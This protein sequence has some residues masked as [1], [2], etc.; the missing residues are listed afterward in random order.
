MTRWRIYSL[1]KPEKINMKLKLPLYLSLCTAL[2]AASVTSLQAQVYSN[3][4]DRTVAVIGNEMIQLSQVESEA[5]MLQFQGYTTDRDLRCMV[6][7]NMME[8]KLFLMQARLDSLTVNADMVESNLNDRVNN[9]M[10]QLGGEREMEEYF[11]KSIFKL[12]QEWR[13]TLNE[14]SL[15]QEMQQSVAGKVP[16]L[17]PKQVAEYYRHTSADSL[18]EVPTQ[19]QISQ[20][21]VYPDRK[22]AELAVR[23]RLLEF[24][25]RVAAGEKFSMLAT[26]YSKDPGSALKGGE[27][28]MASKTIFWPAFSDAA[29]SLKVGQ[30]SPIVETPDG[31]HLLQM[32][33]KKGDMFNVRHILLKPEYTEDDRRTAFERLDSIKNVVTVDSVSFFLA[34]RRFSEDPATRTNGGVLADPNTGSALFEKDQLKPTDYAVLKDMQIGD[35]SAPFES[36]DNEGRNGNTMYKIIR[37]D[38]LIPSHTADLDRD[39]QLLSNMA[40]QQ[41]QSDAVDKFLNEKQKTAYI[42]LDPMFHGCA[43]KRKGWIK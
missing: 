37:L 8:S 3:I 2:A 27:L 22:K 28:G 1:V 42:V 40:R 24:R 43:F 39:L 19:Y 21:A 38:R 16:E 14:Q 29:M 7:E 20:I 6:L 10:T 12:R 23:E 13:E 4:I 26:L 15:V 35:I 11:G 33:E 9:I 17:T 41:L 5:Q 30:V 18:P 25:E 36:S 34:A 31:F 32:I